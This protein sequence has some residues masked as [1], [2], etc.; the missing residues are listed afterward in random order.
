MPGTRL[1]FACILVIVMVSGCDNDPYCPEGTSWCWAKCVD[2]VNDNNNCGFCDNECGPRFE[3][4]DG[5]CT[6][7]EGYSECSGECVDA[8]TDN[9]NCGWCGIACEVG[10]TICISGECIHEDDFDDQDPSVNPGMSEVCGPKDD[11]CDGQVDEEPEASE[12]CDDS[13][14]CTDDVCSGG[15]GCVN[16]V[17]EGAPCDDGNLCTIDDACMGMVCVGLEKE[18]LPIDQGGC[19][20]DICCTAD[21]CD[22]QTG[23]CSN[24][25]DDRLCPQDPC[26]EGPL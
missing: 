26:P 13:S 4:V 19:V 9:E 2:L 11:N 18:M 12:S 20:D 17:R 25:P 22:T 3:C 15:Q 6:C 21:V 7:L 8:L 14:D 5:V 16:I 1:Y 23:R 24:T 10:T